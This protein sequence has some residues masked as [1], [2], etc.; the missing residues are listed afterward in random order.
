LLTTQP[1]FNRVTFSW[2]VIWSGTS[3]A[4]LTYISFDRLTYIQGIADP[5]V[6]NDVLDKAIQVG[7]SLI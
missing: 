6:W 1:F 5:Q 2:N 3:L 7:G 4:V